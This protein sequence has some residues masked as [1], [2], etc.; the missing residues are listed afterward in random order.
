MTP[1]R[2]ARLAAGLLVFAALGY[3][4]LR[5]RSAAATLPASAPLPRAT[6]APSPVDPLVEP[7]AP[8]SVDDPESVVGVGLA[9][10]LPADEKALAT[11]ARVAIVAVALMTF[12]AVSLLAT[13]RV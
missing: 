9:A 4:V 6:A 2:A 13:K 8:E 5:R 11:W 1:V 12:F 3:V 7:V 10:P